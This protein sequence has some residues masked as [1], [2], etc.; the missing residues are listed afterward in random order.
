M[1]KVGNILIEPS[2]MLVSLI[3]CP[4]LLVP[5]LDGSRVVFTVVLRWNLRLKSAADIYQR[6]TNACEFLGIKKE[7]FV[8]FIY[9]KVDIAHLD[10][11]HQRI[12]IYPLLLRV[13]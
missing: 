11:F 4:F 12:R 2:E 8:F 9:L 5:A 1:L 10:I 3:E 7:N 13:V 6:M